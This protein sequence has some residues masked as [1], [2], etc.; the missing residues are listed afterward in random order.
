MTM[1]T[2]NPVLPITVREAC[3]GHAFNYATMWE[4]VDAE[5]KLPWDAIKDN[6][7]DTLMDE[8]WCRAAAAKLNAASGMEAP[9]GG[10]TAQTGSTEGNSPTAAGGDAQP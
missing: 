9:S 8:V 2:H 5:G 4:V 3:L 6:T 1:I 7:P 10:E